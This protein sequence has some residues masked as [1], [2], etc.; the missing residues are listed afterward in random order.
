MPCGPRCR[1]LVSLMLERALSIGLPP[2]VGNRDP[3]SAGTVGEAV[4]LL[5]GHGAITAVGMAVNPQ[6]AHQRLEK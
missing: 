5:G 6:R 4:G 2:G 1:F 3:L